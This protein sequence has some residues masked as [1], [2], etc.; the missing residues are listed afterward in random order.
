[1]DD[2]LSVFAKNRTVELARFPVVLYPRLYVW[3][4]FLGK[5]PWQPVFD[6]L[7]VNLYGHNIQSAEVSAGKHQN[8]WGMITFCTH[9]FQRY[10][11]EIFIL[12]KQV[13]ALG[14]WIEQC[15]SKAFSNNLGDFYGKN[16]FSPRCS[17]SF[18]V[19]CYPLQ[20]KEVCSVK[21][22]VIKAYSQKQHGSSGLAREQEALDKGFDSISS[23]KFSVSMS[24][25]TSL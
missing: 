10:S 6:H 24:V 8:I 13:R 12:K 20:E 16:F 23:L 4:G 11:A 1:M 7:L 14:V 18:H 5:Y 17:C 19:D 3:K 21:T 9:A 2:L 22:H 15:L 25:F